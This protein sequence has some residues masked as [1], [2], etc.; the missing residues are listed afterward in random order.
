V[1]RET[2][3]VVGHEQYVPYAHQVVLTAPNTFDPSKAPR[4]STGE[5]IPTLHPFRGGVDFINDVLDLLER[6]DGDGSHLEAGGPATIQTAITRAIVKLTLRGRALAS[7]SKLLRRL[8]LRERIT[9]TGRHEFYDPRTNRVHAAWDPK[10]SKG[11]NHWHKFD[12]SALP[13][14]SALNEA[15]RIVPTTSTA[16]HIPAK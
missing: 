16:A 14:G 6:L 1:I 5:V 10:N 13:Y 4:V 15:G 7:G 9:K 12:D 2:L 11:G 8:G 3:T